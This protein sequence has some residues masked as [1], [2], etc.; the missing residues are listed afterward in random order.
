LY[1]RTIAHSA[2]HIRYHTTIDSFACSRRV[3]VNNM[4]PSR[5]SL[6]ER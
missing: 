4:N 2:R 6:N 1:R 5:S 3:K